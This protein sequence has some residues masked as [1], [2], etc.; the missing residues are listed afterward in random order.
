M[1]AIVAVRKE[2]F[3]AIAGDMQFVH[4]SIT[5][6]AQM[7]LYPRKIHNIAG[8]YVGVV[9]SVAHHNVLRSLSASKPELFNFDGADEIFETFRKIYPLLREDY[10]LVSKDEHE[11]QEY[12]SSQMDGLVISKAGVFSFSGYREVSE[13]NSFWAA[14][15]GRDFALGAL[16]ATYASGQSAKS[17]AEI[18][19]KAACKFDSASGL[20]LESYEIELGSK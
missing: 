2:H 16:E 15:S 10:H 13:Y 8:A 14:G 1:S 12:E 17:I 20:P 11:D 9:G 3:V 5:I 19:V 6:P 4:G 18:A 7:C